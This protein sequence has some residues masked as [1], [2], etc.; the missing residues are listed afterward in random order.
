MKRASVLKSEKRIKKKNDSEEK[1]NSDSTLCHH[2]QNCVSQIIIIII[3][4]EFLVEI[5]ELWCDNSGCWCKTM[6]RLL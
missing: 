3:I 4:M 2:I 6:P 5:F 1:H